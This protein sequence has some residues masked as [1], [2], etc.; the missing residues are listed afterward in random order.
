LLSSAGIVYLNATAD[1]AAVTI[2]KPVSVQVPTKFPQN[3]MMVYTGSVDD[4]SALSWANPAPLESNTASRQI[5]N[6]HVV[7]MTNCAS[8]HSLRGNVT[9]PP[10]AWITSRRDRR[11]LFEYTRNSARMLWR[12]DA[13][14][15][16]L[17]NR[18]NKRPME[19]FPDLSDSALNDLYEY[20]AFASRRIDSN[21]VIDQKRGFD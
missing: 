17:L 18:Y 11:W 5:D 20:I 15:C 2:G 6:G 12:G 10:L 19:I 7:F 9:G 14:S 21:L 16:Y 8:C 4:S 13:Y 1:G 3:G